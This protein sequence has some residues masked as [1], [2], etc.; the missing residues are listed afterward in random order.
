MKDRII[1][2]DDVSLDVLLQ[3]WGTFWCNIV[4]KKGNRIAN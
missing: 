3:N 4:R 2:L 1:N